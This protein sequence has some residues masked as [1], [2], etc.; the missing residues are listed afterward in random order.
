MMSLM[1]TNMLL[2]ILISASELHPFNLGDRGQSPV[3]MQTGPIH[4]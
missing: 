1:I 2:L 4:D 3:E